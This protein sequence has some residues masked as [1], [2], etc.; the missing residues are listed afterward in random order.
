[1]NAIRLYKAKYLISSFFKD[2]LTIREK[3]FTVSTIKH[4]F[5][6]SGI[7]PVSF[8][9]VKRKLKEYRRKSK[10]DTGLHLLEYGSE[11][12]SDIEDEAIAEPALDPKLTEEYQLPQLKPSSYEECRRRNDELA[13]RILAAAE[14]W[15]SPSCEKAHRNMED[16]NTWLMQGSLGEIEIMQARVAQVEIHKKREIS[17]KNLSKGGSLLA[18]DALQKMATKRQKEANEVLKKATT[19]FTRTKNKQKKELQAEGVQDRKAENERR[20]YIQQHQALGSM[21]PPLL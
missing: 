16:T 11:S 5:Q 6:N 1:M 15:S 18:S 20:Q 10:K 17:R 2:L 3:T 21:I 19:A 13:P 12:E 8:K 14:S 7:W 4:A 9:A